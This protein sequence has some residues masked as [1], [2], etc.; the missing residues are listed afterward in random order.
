MEVPST[1][2]SNLTSDERH[3]LVSILHDGQHTIAQ[4]DH[5]SIQSIIDSLDTEDDDC[6][7]VPSQC[8]AEDI[9]PDQS[10]QET[11]ATSLMA[12]SGNCS[13]DCTVT[14]C[15]NEWSQSA[16]HYSCCHDSQAA[17]LNVE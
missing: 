2:T 14:E 5:E 13:S 15:G 1:C 9:T 7:K 16:S 11:S 12:D 17:S 4:E 8:M 6:I 3:L 10:I